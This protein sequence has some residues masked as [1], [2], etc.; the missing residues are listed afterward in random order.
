MAWEGSTRRARLPR[1]WPARRARV[2]REHGG[3]CHVCKL[4]G[5]DDVDHVRP[6][7]DHGFHNLAPIHRVPCHR[8]KSAREG[9]AASARATQRRRAQRFRE[10]E[11]HPG[12]LSRGGPARP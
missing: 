10:P 9:A 6:G 5:A 11:P 12:L 3:I 7:D 2:L 8:D 1:D 4:P